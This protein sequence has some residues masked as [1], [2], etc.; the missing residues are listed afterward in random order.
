MPPLKKVLIPL[1]VRYIVAT[2][3]VWS[4]LSYVYSKDAVKILSREDIEAR[5]ARTEKTKEA[6]SETENAKK[7]KG[8]HRP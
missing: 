4:G 5:L 7:Q 6:A 3:T 8:E 2:T 1:P